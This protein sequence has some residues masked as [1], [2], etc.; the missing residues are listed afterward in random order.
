MLFEV[1]LVVVPSV[2]NFKLRQIRVQATF[3]TTHNGGSAG[4]NYLRNVAGSGP[5]SGNCGR[6]RPQ[7][8]TLVV[9]LVLLP[10]Q[11]YQLQTLLVLVLQKLLKLLSSDLLL[12]KSI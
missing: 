3:H 6:Y 4:L 10:R 11:L 8:A 1:P 7:L 9:S 5:K 2:I 12:R